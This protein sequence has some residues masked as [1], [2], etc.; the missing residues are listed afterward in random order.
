V[1]IQARLQDGSIHAEQVRVLRQ[2][3]GKVEQVDVSGGRVRVAGTLVDISERVAGLQ[4]PNLRPGQPVIISGLWRTDG[5][6]HA[7]RIE[8]VPR[9]DIVTE[10]SRPLRNGLAVLQ[11]V[12]AQVREG[13]VQLVNGPSIRLSGDVPA[14]SPGALATVVVEVDGADVV[15]R[16]LAVTDI[17]D[18]HQL[19]G[20]PEPEAPIPADRSGRAG[21]DE[22]ASLSRA[23]YNAAGVHLDAEAGLHERE[24]AD[25]PD[26]TETPEFP[27]R[28]NA[29]DEP[30]WPQ[31]PEPPD[32][33]EAPDLPEQPEVLDL[34]EPPDEAD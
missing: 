5:V 17:D 15:S 6:L 34:P 30:D 31:V 7:T 11:G 2:L 24:V 1:D 9:H 33:P 27:E 3:V 26:A 12:V 13:E 14:P 21:D 10:S 19:T 4:I 32:E 8:P 16:A 28:Q 20:R 23:P 29:P 18:L 25:E 22:R